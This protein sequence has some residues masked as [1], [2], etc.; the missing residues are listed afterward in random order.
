[1]ISDLLHELKTDSL[2]KIINE[3]LGIIHRKNEEFE[4]ERKEEP[5]EEIKEEQKEKKVF[6]KPQD[7]FDKKVNI[8][9]ADYL[10]AK[11]INQLQDNIQKVCKIY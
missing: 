1:M 2:F 4:E 9:V 3:D 8:M 11:K 5:K 7:I 6:F 10:S